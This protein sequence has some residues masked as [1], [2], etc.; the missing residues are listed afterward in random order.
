MIQITD[1]L[2]LR[3]YDGKCKFAL[4]WYQDR[5]LL[6]LVDGKESKP[7]NMERLIKMYEYLSDRGE[8]Y[9]IEV[10]QGNNFVPIGDVTLSMEDLSIVIGERG[11]RG[12]GIGS[13]VIEALKLRASTLGYKQLSVREIYDYNIASQKLFEKQGFDKVKKTDKGYSYRCIL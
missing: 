11:Y 5:E 3:T 13:K 10:K 12:E 1:T 2:R 7:Y 8:L 4:E 9:F 6:D